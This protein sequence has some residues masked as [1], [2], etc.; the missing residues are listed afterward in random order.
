[1]TRTSPPDRCLAVLPPAGAL[2]WSLP[3]NPGSQSLSTSSTPSS[4][5]SDWR[6]SVARGVSHPRR[7]LPGCWVASRRPAGFLPLS[8]PSGVP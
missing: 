4:T 6:G 3:H 2:R 8:M 1:M 5:T 7:S